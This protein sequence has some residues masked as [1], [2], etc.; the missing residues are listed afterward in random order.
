MASVGEVRLNNMQG[1][2]ATITVSPTNVFRLRLW[3]GLKLFRLAALVIGASSIVK[4]GWEE[5]R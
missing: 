1:I 2:A 4:V 3:V 5:C